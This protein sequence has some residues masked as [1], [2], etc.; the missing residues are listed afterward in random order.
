MGCLLALFAGSFPRVALLIFWLLRP[1]LVDAAFDTWIWPFLGLIFLP[2]ATLLYTILHV[3]EVGLEGWEWFWVA[4]A[5]LF[6]IAHWGAAFTQRS[7][8]PGIQPGPPPPPP[9]TGLP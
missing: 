7:D 9:A 5:A 8:V 3:P 1:A 4:V 2:F 6:D